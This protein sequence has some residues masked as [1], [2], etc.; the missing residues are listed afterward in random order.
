MVALLKDR[1]VCVQ[2]IIAGAETRP[3]DLTR[4]R[5]Q[6][7]ERFAKNGRFFFGTIRFLAPDGKEV[8]GQLKCFPGADPDT[9]KQDGAKFVALARNIL[10]RQPAKAEEPRQEPPAIFPK[11]KD[12]FGPKKGGPALGS[13]APDFELKYLAA[14]KTFKLSTNFGKKPTVLIFHSFT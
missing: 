5:R 4:E 7:L 8:L 2:E 11:F 12:G 1:F 3:E 14:D 10:E 13:Q 6:Q 9:R